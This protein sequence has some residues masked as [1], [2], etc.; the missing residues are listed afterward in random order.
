MCG[1]TK[2]RNVLSADAEHAYN[3]YRNKRKGRRLSVPEREVDRIYRSQRTRR[4]RLVY[5]GPTKINCLGCGA[6]FLY[7]AVGR[8]RQPDYHSDA[9]KQKSYREL[10]TGALTTPICRSPFSERLFSPTSTSQKTLLLR[11]IPYHFPFHQF[12]D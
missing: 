3:H 6:P 8:G 9:C 10:H 5:E 2:F 7:E 4:V 11:D 1:K 12:P